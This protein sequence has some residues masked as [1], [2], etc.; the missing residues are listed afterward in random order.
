MGLVQVPFLVVSLINISL[1]LY[2]TPYAFNSAM[3]SAPLPFSTSIFSMRWFSVK[4]V[5]LA[6]P[7]PRLFLLA[8]L[9]GVVLAGGGMYAGLLPLPCQ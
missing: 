3:T 9:F 2:V 8:E 6:I 5:V 1:L 4:F 7:L